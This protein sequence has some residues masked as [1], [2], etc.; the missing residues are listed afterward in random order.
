MHRISL[1]F[2]FLF[3]PLVIFADNPDWKLEKSTHFFVYYKNAPQA[4]IDEL[5][6]KAESYYNSL[7]ENLG[8]NRFDFWLWDNRAKIYLFDTKE[9]YDKGTNSLGWSAGQVAP[10]S[11]I[12]RS[13]VTAPG[14][15]NNVLPHELAHIILLEMVGFNNPAVPLWLQEGV[16]S[17]QGGND[18]SSDANLA[19]NIKKGNFIDLSG[20]NSFELM[21]SSDKEKVTLFYAQAHSLV[22]YLISEFGKDQFVYFCQ[23]LRDSKDLTR[24]LAKTY[25]FS[26]FQELQNSW[27]AYILK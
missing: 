12:I 24:S 19:L 20:F 25:S 21:N 2:L 8:F 15:L 18:Y 14:F 27:K 3:F 22:K 6:N 4:T 23:N 9:E 17:F 1:F 10:N 5:I 26:N 16:A 13:F 11:K 7:T